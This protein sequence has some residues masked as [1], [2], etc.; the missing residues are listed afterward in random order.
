MNR[1]IRRLK[2]KLIEAPKGTK[3][4]FFGMKV[5]DSQRIYI[6]TCNKGWMSISG[7]LPIESHNTHIRQ[8]KEAK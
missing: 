6:C 2:H 5:N 7:K 4:P 3:P 8:L 1:A